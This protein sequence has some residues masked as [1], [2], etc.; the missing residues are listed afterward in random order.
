MGGRA[1]WKGPFFVNFPNLREALATNVP[2][3]T[4]ARACTILPSFVGVKF[5]VHNGKDFLPVKVTEEM[6][7]HKLGEFSHTRK[8]FSYRQTKN[9]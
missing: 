5:L 4:H 7:G 6:V 1:A 3:K 2:I 8:R 9:K